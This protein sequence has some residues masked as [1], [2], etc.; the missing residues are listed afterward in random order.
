MFLGQLADAFPIQHL[1][2]RGVGCVN[3]MGFSDLGHRFD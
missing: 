3:G 1:K 2:D